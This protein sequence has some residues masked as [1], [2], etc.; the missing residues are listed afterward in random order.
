[1]CGLTGFLNTSLNINSS[2]AG[3]LILKMS[4]T[5]AHRGPDDHGVWMDFSAGIALGHR[6]LSI[7]DLS[8]EGHQPMH[9]ACGR[10]VMVYNGEIY[11]FL[12]IKREL[13]DSGVTTGW[14]GHSDT[15]VMLAA[16]SHWGLEQAITRFVGMFAFALWDRK[17]RI[18]KL[19]RDRLGEKPLYY[20]WMKKTFLF[21]S[22]LKALRSHPDW[23][24]EIDRTVLALLMRYNYI[25]APYSIYRNIF[26]ILPGTIITI[27]KKN[28]SAPMTLPVH[29]NYYWS[30]K[31]VAEQGEKEPLEENEE[32]CIKLL[33]S[34]L[35]NAVRGQ[36]KADVPL[37][38]F[39]S[40]GVD[41]STIVALMQTQSTRRIKTFTIGFE[42]KAY[43]EAHDAKAVAKH[44]GTDHTELYV[45]PKEAMSVIPQLPSLYDEPFSDS[46]QIPTYLISK[47]TRQ[48]VTVS[49]SGDGGDELFGGYNRYFW[50]EKIWEKINYCPSFLRQVL[51]LGIKALSPMA[52][53]SIFQV[54]DPVFP[55]KMKQRNPGDKLHK[56]AGILTSKHPEEMYLRLVSHW[57]APESIVPESKE[58][59][60]MPTDPKTWAR[61]KDFTRAIMYLDLACYLPDDILV[62]VDRASMGVSLETRV[63][64]LDHRVVEFA[65]K[66]PLHMKIRNNQG[67]WLLRQVL[68][69]YVP[70]ELIERP[71]MGFGV[72]L[73][74]WLR[75]PLRDWAEDLLSSNKLKNE[76]F[77]NPE[78]IGKIWQAHLSGKGNYQHH[79]WDVLMFQ[80]WLRKN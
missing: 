29:P 26:K 44:L 69:K 4:D 55:E 14:H 50:G 73:D 68:Y 41:S 22:E 20:G 62:K 12:E 35:K 34:H 36:M 18:L 19:T 17:E 21:G 60:T 1:M 58:V 65:C 3:E 52:W 80:A 40:G 67:K 59:P 66:V 2:E 42:E 74:S 48:Q 39:L 43:N 77:F 37:G 46:S 11:N 23:E 6:R 7:I 54:L 71:K 15:E 53:D 64:F 32:E 28:S 63:P 33:E 75:G 56:I 10:Y 72:P 76:G 79:L 51:N 16:I 57:D 30:S 13:Q 31:I 25:P 49:L 70:K 38:A 47:L 24:G 9:S 5:L 78:P 27:D 61:I 45:T 8:S